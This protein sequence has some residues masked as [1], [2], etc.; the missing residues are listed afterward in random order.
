MF[1]HWVVELN[2]PF[3]SPPQT[4]ASKLSSLY[5]FVARFLLTTSSS[6]VSPSTVERIFVPS[7]P[8]VEL[9]AEISIPL[10]HTHEISNIQFSLVIFGLVI[11][12]QLSPVSNYL[13]TT[14]FNFPWVIQFF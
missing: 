11:Q 2:V 10:V 3:G 5:I 13:F 1:V 9:G 14:S 8:P 6:Y 7:R 12:R 4:G